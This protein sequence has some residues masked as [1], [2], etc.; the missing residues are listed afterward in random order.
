MLCAAIARNI[1]WK[2]H[3]SVSSWFRLAVWS[4]CWNTHRR[5]LD[6]QVEPTPKKDPFAEG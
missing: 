2:P 5:S 4:F 3:V 6:D 1:S